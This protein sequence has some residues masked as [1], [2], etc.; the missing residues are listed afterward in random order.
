MQGCRVFCVFSLIYILSLSLWLCA[1]CV[2]SFSGARMSKHF[3]SN[4]LIE[5]ENY[6]HTNKNRLFF[7]YKCLSAFDLIIFDLLF[8][9]KQQ[10]KKEQKICRQVRLIFL[11]LLFIFSLSLFNFLSRPLTWKTN[12]KLF[13]NSCKLAPAWRCITLAVGFIK[14][15]IL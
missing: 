11:S 9:I 14:G 4:S 7:L 5:E 13:F 1:V 6:P 2:S 3:N 12:K 15:T 10:R 8:Q